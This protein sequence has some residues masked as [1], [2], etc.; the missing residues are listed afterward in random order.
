MG[1]FLDKLAYLLIALGAAGWAV[2]VLLYG[3]DVRY[4]M[5]SVLVL[6][7]GIFVGHFWEELF[8]SK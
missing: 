4:Q 7:I 6:T 3:G 8:Y 1:K 2:S 5:L